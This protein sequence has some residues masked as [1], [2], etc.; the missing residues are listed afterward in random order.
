MN[1]PFSTFL[2]PVLQALFFALFL[3]FFTSCNSDTR[4]VKKFVKR[5]NAGELNASSEYI[6]PE[7]HTKLYVFYMKYLNNKKLTS[8]EYEDG[9]DFSIGD[10]NYV[11]AQFKCNNCDSAIINYFAEKDKYDGEFIIDTFEIKTAHDQDYLSLN[12]S[13]DESKISKNLK[14]YEDTSN[15]IKLRNKPNLKSPVE[16]TIEKNEKILVDEDY[17]NPEWEKALIIDDESSTSIK[18]F[19]SKKTNIKSDVSFLNLGLME[20]M[21][22]ILIAL[23][24]IFC[25][26]IAFPLLLVGLFR[27]GGGGGVIAIVFLFTLIVIVFYIGYQFLEKFIFEVFL[28]NLPY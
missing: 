11:V 28:I 2:K 21:S 16:I 9:D 8:L 4:L 20:G 22:I 26:V 19:R 5:I 15:I 10:K 3:C 24:A 17:I 25:F 23:I 18:Y 14:F 1:Y 12:W 7:D 6:W 27:G 13:W